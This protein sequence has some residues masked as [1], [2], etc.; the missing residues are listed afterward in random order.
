M[1]DKMNFKNLMI[2]QICSISLFL[3]FFSISFFFGQ[4]NQYIFLFV[5]HNLMQFDNQIR[6]YIIIINNS[7]HFSEKVQ[8]NFIIIIKKIGH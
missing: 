8:N 3:I 2:Y 4:L 5:F 1:P 6:T 7:F